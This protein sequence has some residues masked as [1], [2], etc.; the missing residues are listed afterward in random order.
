M[1]S[2]LMC[3]SFKHK[4]RKVSIVI[5]HAGMIQT[6]FELKKERISTF[7][8]RNLFFKTNKYSLQQNFVRTI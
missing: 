6:K 3:R 7:Y 1:T 2:R 5:C 8:G 4:K